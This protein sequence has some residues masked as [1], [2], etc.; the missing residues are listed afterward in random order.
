[1]PTCICVG[2][3]RYGNV[4]ILSVQDTWEKRLSYFQ[5]TVEL[6]AMSSEIPSTHNDDNYSLPVSHLFE[7]VVDI[8]LHGMHVI[9]CT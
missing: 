1:M 9:T 5:V 6:I 8:A 7:T 3:K 2:T 4:C